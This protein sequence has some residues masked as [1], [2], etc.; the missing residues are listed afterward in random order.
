VTDPQVGLPKVA[1][2][3]LRIVVPGEPVP[4][5]RARYRIVRPK[6]GGAPFVQEYTPPETR[7]YEAKVKLL[8]QVAVNQSGWSWAKDDRFSL[9]VRIVRSHW[10]AG[11]DAS[12]VLKAVEDGMN[13]VAYKDDR[14]VR[15]IGVAITDPDPKKPRV[16]IEVR[17]FTLVKPKVKRA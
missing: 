8:T 9:V 12:N 7:A 4:K 10:D 14:Y 3:V 1:P 13:G 11:G 5:G 17:R 15:G 6:A 16:E 2:T